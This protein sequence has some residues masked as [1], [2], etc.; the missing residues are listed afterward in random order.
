MGKNGC[1][2]T[3]KGAKQTLP[4]LEQL[5]L[6]AAAINSI[7]TLLH[8]NISSCTSGCPDILV[9]RAAMQ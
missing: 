1:Q 3:L 2:F 5:Q 7:Y 9:Y 6:H 4:L 8:F